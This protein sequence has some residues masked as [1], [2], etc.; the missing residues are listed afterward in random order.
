MG[1]RIIGVGGTI[2]AFVLGFRA[3]DGWNGSH[4]GLDLMIQD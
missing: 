3:R 4:G 1:V 2:V